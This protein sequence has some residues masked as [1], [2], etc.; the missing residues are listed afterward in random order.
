M[1]GADKTQRHRRTETEQEKKAKVD[2]K[3]IKQKQQ[4]AIS[5]EHKKHFLNSLKNKSINVSSG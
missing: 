5:Q 4:V 2:N 1:R 3:A